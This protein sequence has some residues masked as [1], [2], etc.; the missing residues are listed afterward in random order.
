MGVRTASRSVPLPD[1]YTVATDEQRFAPQ[2][3]LISYTEATVK[4]NLTRPT[5]APLPEGVLT[6][7]STKRRAVSREELSRRREREL[8]RIARDERTHDGRFL[9]RT[10]VDARERR[11]ELVGRTVE[12]T[13]KWRDPDNPSNPFAL[14]ASVGFGRIRTHIHAEQQEWTHAQW[15]PSGTLVKA[16]SAIAVERMSKALDRIAPLMA[17]L[18][19]EFACVY[20]HRGRQRGFQLAVASLLPAKGPQRS[21]L[22]VAAVNAERSTEELVESL[23]RQLVRQQQPSADGSYPLSY[24]VLM[25][26][27]I[28]SYADEQESEWLRS[29]WSNSYWNPNR[30]APSQAP[31]QD[32]TPPDPALERELEAMLAELDEEVRP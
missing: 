29:S 9:S 32:F 12:L 30:P 26:H 25:T 10:I 3:P 1:L 28:E 27:Y 4:R 13:E 6:I 15:H 21:I 16:R 22:S 11:E 31:P 23:L 19:L 20:D 8:A 14:D 24:D 2:T 7:R 17:E 18:E 5:P